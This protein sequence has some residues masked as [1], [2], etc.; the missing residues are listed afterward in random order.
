MATVYV[1]AGLQKALNSHGQPLDSPAAV[2][3]HLQSPSTATHNS[4]QDD[5][6]PPRKRTKGNDGAAVVVSALAEQE[7]VVLAK[8][9]VL[10]VGYFASF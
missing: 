7:T 6:E 2:L 8:L 5:A 4:T 3:S 10:L 9:E 1:E